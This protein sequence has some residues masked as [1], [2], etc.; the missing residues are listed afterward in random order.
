MSELKEIISELNLPKQL[1]DKSEALLKTLFGPS[2]D[3]LGGMIADQVRIRRFKNQLKI[4]EKAQGILKEKNIDPQKV[5]LKV[6][7]PLIEYSSLEED[8]S[9]QD[10]WSNLTSS[11]L[12]GNEDILFQQQCVS[13]LSKLSSEEAT[14]I[15]YLYGSLQRSKVERKERM[16]SRGK[17]P[18]EIPQR[19]AA[20]LFPFS[21]SRLAQK[22]N[23]DQEKFSFR[24]TNLII[25]G[26]LKW[27]TQVDVSATGGGLEAEIDVE[28]DVSNND[29]FIFTHFGE[30]F[31]EMCK[32][33]V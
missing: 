19:F 5:N 2:F 1:L 25:L 10:K 6:L 12:A 33:S 27:E 11:I 13:V 14:L 30:K 7:A 31:V 16:I 26:L 20:E 8:E 21:E 15:D 4:F 22:L 29:I 3:E 17:P 24:I 18:E 32:L 9:L 23:T 28:V